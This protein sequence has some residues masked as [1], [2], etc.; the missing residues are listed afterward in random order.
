[1]ARTTL[2]L[3]DETLDSLKDYAGKNSLSVS[4]AAER[5]LCS[6]L[7]DG[8]EEGSGDVQ[9]ALIL[10]RLDE[11]KASQE[12][13]MADFSERASKIMARGTKASLASLIANATY[14]PAVANL[15]NSTHHITCKGWGSVGFEL[16]DQAVASDQA[17]LLEL[18]DKTPAEMLK[19][20][21]AAGGRASVAGS[22]MDYAEITRGLIDHSFSAD[23][24]ADMPEGF[25]D[26]IQG[27]GESGT[28]QIALERIQRLDG[29]MDAL[30]TKA[31]TKELSSLDK[32]RYADYKAERDA[33]AEAFQERRAKTIGKIRTSLVPN[34]DGTWRVDDEDE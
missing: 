24:L 34:G 11:L 14:L 17:L 8:A 10:E 33:L 2:Y 32:K 27:R 19:F 4:A 21:W 20:C 1:M 23:E 29:W 12:K 26:L 9:T 28:E 15:T 22:K 18:R 5:L 3:S 16:R 31:Q 7:S 30:D 25:I 13:G 6:A